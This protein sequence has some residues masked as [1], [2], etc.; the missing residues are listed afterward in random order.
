M[1]RLGAAL[2]VVAALLIV[3]AVPAAAQETTD[4]LDL[5]QMGFSISRDAGFP[6]DVVTGSVDTDDVADFCLSVDELV[7]NIVTEVDEAL[8]EWLDG[9]A[10]DGLDEDQVEL[11][12]EVVE[13]LRI[14][15]QAFPETA[16]QFWLETFVFTFADIETQEL[17]GDTGNFDPAT[18][19]GSV[20]VPHL[21]PDT[22]G[23]AAA[24]VQLL[25]AEALVDFGFDDGAI[26]FWDWVEENNIEVPDPDIL[27]EDEWQVFVEESAL[28][29][30]PEL[31]DPR[32]V[33]IELFC[34]LN[35]DGTCGD[36]AEVIEDPP[37]DDLVPEAPSPGQPVDVEPRF[38]G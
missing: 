5:P 12:G 34:I 38:T 31:I 16:E 10:P 17:L 28:E 30:V 18:G 35:P 24:C 36:A 8:P 9:D 25:P 37:A 15:V 22:Y 7:G 21:P 1:S 20:V 23:L 11:F 26:A 29:W 2:A 14:G 13:T 3:P 33:G 19:E 32:A 4:V 6:G 27:D